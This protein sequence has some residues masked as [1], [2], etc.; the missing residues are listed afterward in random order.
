MESSIINDVKVN[1]NLL[2]GRDELAVG[3]PGHVK[4]LLACNRLRLVSVFVRKINDLR[5][6]R[7][8]S[9]FF[10]YN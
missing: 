1:D 5:W 8:K 7:K 2:V 9:D 4:Q 10:W 3:N 6:K